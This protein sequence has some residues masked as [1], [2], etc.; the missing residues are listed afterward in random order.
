VRAALRH[1]LDAADTFEDDLA[2]LVGLLDGSGPVTAH[3]IAPARVPVSLLAT[4]RGLAIAARQGL[5]VVVGG[6]ILAQDSI[7]DSLDA[8]RRDFRPG[9]QA[10]EPHVTISLDVTVAADD[11]TARELALPEAWAMARSRQTGEF[12]PLEPVDAI[13]AQ[14]WSRQVRDRV[15]SSLDRAVAGSPATVRRMLD[16]LAARTGADELMA[17]TSTYDRV[18]LLESDRLLRDLVP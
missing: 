3:P 16:D 1:D 18:A 9:K 4:G 15:E 7:R 11:A 17:S 12:P 6:P 8:Y 14:A 13:R 2:E 5:P 10:A